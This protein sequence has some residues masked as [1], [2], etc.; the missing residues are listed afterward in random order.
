[1][2]VL[3]SGG[4]IAGLTLAFWLHSYGHEPL[5][6]ERSSKVRDEGYM[7]DFFGPGY[8]ASEKMGLLPEIEGIHYQIPRLAFF[9][10]SGK[11]RFS[12][13]YATLRRNLFG[14]RHFNFM[15]GDLERLLY[16]KIEDRVEVRLGTSVDSFEQDGAKVRVKL[17]DGTTSS[18]DVLVGADGVHSRVRELAFGTEESFSRSL[19]YYTAAYIVDDARMREGVGGAFYTLTVPGRQVAVYPI[20]GGRL[21]TF[22]IHKAEHLLP[23]FSPQTVRA[24]LHR[25][26]GGMGWIV[27]ELLERCHQRSRVYFDE[28]AQI[29]MSGWSR[30]GVVLVGDACGCVSLLAGQ[31]ASMA[32]CGAYTLAE[33]FGAAQE[34]EEDIAAALTRYESKLR[35]PV[36]K[37]QKAGRRLAR[38]FV[39]ED[40]ARLVVRDAVMRMTTSSLASLVL[41][42]GFA[43]GNT[44]KL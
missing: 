13:S 37:R 28:V 9:A 17:T 22:F 41:R 4:G 10:P 31:G 15:R 7:I 16:S 20:S 43:W 21:A 38:W 18:F 30:G 24:Q 14:D 6:V 42:Y 40:H 2:N 35:P 12:L 44:A 19:G 33:E 11:E 5:V 36:Q 8:D 26:Y 3:I 27:P 25:A 29:E 32:V 23:D 39:P 34:G 1:M